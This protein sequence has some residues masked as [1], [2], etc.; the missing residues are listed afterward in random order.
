M[1]S[2]RYDVNPTAHSEIICAHEP[3]G[4]KSL[5]GRVKPGHD[6]DISAC[7]GRN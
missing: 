5:D 4:N 1:R 6:G 3:L 7:I 2:I